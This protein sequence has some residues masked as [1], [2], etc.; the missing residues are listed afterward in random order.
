MI[1]TFHRLLGADKLIADEANGVVMGAGHLY[2]FCCQRP[3]N[4]H[5]TVVQTAPQH[6]LC[7]L[8]G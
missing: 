5:V 1:V 7:V 8:Y 6:F 4:I 3:P 2:V